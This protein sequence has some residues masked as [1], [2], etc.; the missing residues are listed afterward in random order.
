MFD[1][2]INID[3]SRIQILEIY[4]T[5]SIFGN[6]TIK[7]SC[8]EGPGSTDILEKRLNTI[9]NCLIGLATLRIDGVLQKPIKPKTTGIRKIKNGQVNKK[10]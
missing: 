2:V 8:P 3:H 4:L 6:M 9:T 1:K 5:E 10:K 7:I